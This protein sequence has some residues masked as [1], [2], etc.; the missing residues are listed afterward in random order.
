MA[1]RDIQLRIQRPGPRGWGKDL[2]AT[3]HIQELGI[4]MITM[5]S[6]VSPLSSLVHQAALPSQCLEEPC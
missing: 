6:S 5:A 1:Y 4:L 2:E 3:G